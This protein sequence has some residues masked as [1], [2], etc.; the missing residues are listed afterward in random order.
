MSSGPNPW[1][2][3]FAL[4]PLG[5]KLPTDGKGLPVLPFDLPGFPKAGSGRDGPQ[6]AAEDAVGDEIDDLLEQSRKLRT[7]FS[8]KRGKLLKEYRAAERSVEKLLD[9]SDP[10]QSRCARCAL[11]APISSFALLTCCC[12]G[13]WQWPATIQ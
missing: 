1:D 11:R 10:V 2:A 13:L 3:P 8:E 9:A 7:E 12:V 6:N 4:P 5:S